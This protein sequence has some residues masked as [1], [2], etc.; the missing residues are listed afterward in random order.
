[1]VSYFSALTYIGFGHFMH[2]TISPLYF[3][4]AESSSKA[5]LDELSA[6][7]ATLEAKKGSLKKSLDESHTTA[8][9]AES[10]LKTKA[11]EFRK[12]M[13]EKDKLVDHAQGAAK[14]AKEELAEQLRLEKIFHDEI[15]GKLGICTTFS[16][17]SSVSNLLEVIFL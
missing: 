12:A 16:A 2:W 5:K 8:I 11:E 17:T 13:A 4:T 10:A 1:M 14:A 15:F 7:F 9:K 6:K 3:A